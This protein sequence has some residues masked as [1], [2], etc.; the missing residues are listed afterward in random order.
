MS[1]GFITCYF[2]YFF[3]FELTWLVYFS[4]S[5]AYGLH[6]NNVSYADAYAPSSMRHITLVLMHILIQPPSSYTSSF[7]YK[8]SDGAETH[9]PST[10]ATDLTS[11]FNHLLGISPIP[12]LRVDWS[13]TTVK[14]SADQMC[15]IYQS[16]LV[17]MSPFSMVTPYC[18]ANLIPGCWPNEYSMMLQWFIPDEMLCHQ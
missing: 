16:V 12:N 7:S 2:G 8:T 6:M 5:R 13:M 18:Q 14:P 10:H 3:D 4:I 9:H 1:T 17:T 11:G 15:I